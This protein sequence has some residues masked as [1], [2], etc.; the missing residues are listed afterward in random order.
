MQYQYINI[1]HNDIDISNHLI[2]Y[3]REKQICTGIGTLTLIL[4]QTYTTDINTWDEIRIEEDYEPVGLFYIGEVAKSEPDYIITITAQD[5]SKKLTDYFIAEEYLVDYP[6][7]NVYWIEKFLTECGV[8]YSI[9][10]TE[11]S[12][13][14]NESTLGHMSVYEQVIQLI[15]MSGWY[16]Y[17]DFNN[18]LQIG[19]LDRNIQ[20]SACTLDDTDE[21]LEIVLDQNDSYLRNRAVVWGKADEDAETWVF[22]DVH[23]HTRWNYDENDLRT[24]IL[25]NNSIP[26][27]ASARNIANSILREFST[28][29][30]TKEVKIEGFAYNSD[31]SRALDVGDMV[32]INNYVYTGDGLVTSIS[33]D[34]SG[35]GSTTT[36]ILDEKCP[37]LYS[38]Y[39][40][41]DRVYIGTTEDGVYARHIK[42]APEWFNRSQGLGTDLNI[43]DLHVNNGVLSCVSSVGRMYHCTKST[44]WKELVISSLESYEDNEPIS[45]ES[46]MI[47]YSDLR[48]R[49]TII[50]R[51]SNRLRYA[52]DTYSGVNSADYDD[53]THEV[54]DTGARTWI[55]DASSSMSLNQY[56]AFPI[57]ISGY[58]NI[59]AFDLENDGYYDYIT[60]GKKT[61]EGEGYDFGQLRGDWDSTT[62]VNLP[63]SPVPTIDKSSLKTYTF[64][65]SIFDRE[66]DS[67]A[68]LLTVVY[69]SSIA[70]YRLIN[71][72]T[73]A[74]Y[75]TSPA[76]DIPM[77]IDPS[78]LEIKFSERFT[79]NIFRIYGF[80]TGLSSDTVYM[81]SWNIQTNTVVRTEFTA[82]INPYASGGVSVSYCTID[83]YAYILYSWYKIGLTACR[84]DVYKLGGGA[85]VS[86]GTAF[87]FPVEYGTDYDGN[88]QVITFTSLPVATICRVGTTYSVCGF[89]ERHFMYRLYGYVRYSWVYG[90][91]N[92]GVTVLD[93]G[94]HNATL[95]GLG[96]SNSAGET[97]DHN[98]F[99]YTEYFDTTGTLKYAYINGESLIKTDSKTDMIEI[100]SHGHTEYPIFHSNTD[101][102]ISHTDAFSGD[103]SYEWYYINSETGALIG[104]VSIAGYT[105]LGVYPTADEITGG[106]YWLATKI[107]TGSTY[108]VYTSSGGGIFWATLYPYVMSGAG[109][110]RFKNCGNIFS[111]VY[112]N[113]YTVL[114]RFN[115]LPTTKYYL[116][117]RDPATEEIIVMDERSR[118][119]RLD[120]AL[121]SPLISALD[122]E[123]TFKSYYSYADKTYTELS[124]NSFSPT[125]SNKVLDYRVAY[126]TASGVEDIESVD[127]M[128]LYTCD[129]DSIY[130]LSTEILEEST[131]LYSLAN[132]N[133]IETTNYCSPN[134]YIF[135]SIDETV[136]SFYQKDDDSET[137]V[138]YSSGLPDSYINIIR[139]DDRV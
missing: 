55:V 27:V 30:I 131:N 87:D 52:I 108:L 113:V 84:G 139:I 126:L 5:G 35:N 72:Y 107:S 119:I 56:E 79:D 26:D 112:S 135:V 32:F 80:S 123:Y 16:M 2:S 62:I 33:V 129:D 36:L 86:E 61:A 82:P 69:I 64:P 47:E 25:S 6:S 111:V 102:F 11:S 14:A 41:G 115:N 138:E 96:S 128:V 109:L 76:V 24:V 116:L 100:L 110:S 51:E 92:G 10:S 134:Q 106:F 101:K 15:Q 120:M 114:I 105:P 44:N 90:I 78:D 43:T 18:V 132:V 60:V 58:Y 98:I 137:F 88:P 8:D 63:I 124:L 49:A 70:Y 121:F 83:A 73:M 28:I 46:T 45:P 1:Y 67:E 89:L 23:T 65:V 125:S 20:N 130:Y 118:P 66:N 37:R 122:K 54:P 93:E 103:S 68:L 85:F 59:H 17:F 75:I 22:A 71:A 97:T 91:L 48:C 117:R 133:K 74:T 21:I 7:T 12:L 3:T 53:W 77:K 31:D 42:D 29:L 9:N 127:K 34:V 95:F 104:E 4:D 57:S 39:D 40:F 94:Y 38:M 81:D 99:L 50:D 136:P 19:K 13:L